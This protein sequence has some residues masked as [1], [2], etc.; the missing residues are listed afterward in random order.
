MRPTVEALWRIA[1]RQSVPLAIAFAHDRFPSA[2]RRPSAMYLKAYQRVAEAR[3]SIGASFE[4]YNHERLHQALD[5]RAPRQAFEDELRLAKLLAREK[6][7]L[8]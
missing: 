2:Q 4:F 6:N 8:C 3:P 1:S 5:Y 7:C